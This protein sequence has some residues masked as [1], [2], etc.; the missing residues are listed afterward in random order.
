[1]IS[2][3]LKNALTDSKYLIEVLRWGNYGPS[4]WGNGMEPNV[5]HGH[6]PGAPNY[7]GSFN[8]QHRIPYGADKSEI[9]WLEI[10]LELNRSMGA[11]VNDIDDMKAGL[12]KYGNRIEFVNG[13]P[14]LLLV[15]DTESRDKL[16]NAL[17]H[18][19]GRGFKLR[20]IQ[21]GNEWKIH[22]GITP[23]DI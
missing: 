21:V 18:L 11:M 19:M 2:I 23:E 9:T 5:L 3:C 14:T 1:V 7:P 8:N 13:D 22:I 4:G 15:P 20:S 12:G 6:N 10:L 17:C 16:T